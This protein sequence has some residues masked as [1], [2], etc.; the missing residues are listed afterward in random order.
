MLP[1]V[2]PCLL[3]NSGR[4]AGQKTIVAQSRTVK[5]IA[6]SAGNAMSTVVLLVTV[7]CLSRVLSVLEYAKYRQI[8]L[9]YQFFVPLVTLALPSAIFY[10]LPSTNKNQRGLLY[11]NISLLVAASSIFGLVLICGGSGLLASRFDNPTIE[12]GLNWIAVFAVLSAAASPTAACL[13]VKERITL[14]SA[15]NVVT[16]VTTG[17]AVVGAAVFFHSAIAS[18][19]AMVIASVFRLVFAMTV[20]LR[21]IRPDYVRM[22][23]TRMRS[24]LFYAIPFGLASMLGSLTL[25]LD[26]FIVAA[27]CAP[28][29]FAIY[30]NGAIELPVIGIVTGSI[31]TII[32]ADMRRAIVG[33]DENAAR[34]LFRRAA[35]KSGC[36][37]LPLMCVLFVVADDLIV[38]LF[39]D[40][41]AESVL[42]FRLYLL[43]LPIRIAFFGTALMAL[44]MSS[45]V[46]YRGIIDL[47][48]NA[49]LS[50]VF[51]YYW[52]SVGAAIATVVMLYV[53]HVPFNMW[54]T[55]KGF[56]CR[57]VEVYPFKQL[58][59]ILVASILAACLSQFI[60]NIVNLEIRILRLVLCSIV[61]A[62]AFGVVGKIISRDVHDLLVKTMRLT[63][64]PRI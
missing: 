55:A 24:M 33:G 6:L 44:G 43:F 57:L 49:A 34:L 7:A 48:L 40:S 45:A 15:Y 64:K 28:T 39:S 56:G 21:V 30:S 63:M 50:V 37:L 23:L 58:A 18:I 26:K 19:I 46:F 32:L 36:F 53:W 4:D 8:L 42:P 61:F 54:V 13:T 27:M 11:E 59:S 3:C 17:V 9:V 62:V 52:G 2:R 60:I 14:L 25:Q 22:Q 12:N 41:Y 31:A 51:V 29:E 5:T 16:R 1:N 47:L 10:F 38:L 20:M 35:V